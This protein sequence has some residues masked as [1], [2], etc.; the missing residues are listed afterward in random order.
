VENAP[1]GKRAHATQYSRMYHPKKQTRFESVG[2]FEN[3]L[4]AFNP[5]YLP[6]YTN[7]PPFAILFSPLNCFHRLSSQAFFIIKF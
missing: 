3:V 6:T 7:L 5:S 4:N 1:P 2:A